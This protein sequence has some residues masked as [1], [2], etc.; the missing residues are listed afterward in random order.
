MEAAIYRPDPSWDR[1]MGTYYMDTIIQLVVLALCA[2]LIWGTEYRIRGQRHRRK[3]KK[4]SYSWSR[5]SGCNDAILLGNW[6]V[7]AMGFT[8][9]RVRGHIYCGRCMESNLVRPDRG[10]FNWNELRGH[11]VINNIGVSNGEPNRH[12]TIY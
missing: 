8:Y 10:N 12:Y 4:A 6:G 9:R 1:Y 3:D 11:S 7:V 5:C 2:S